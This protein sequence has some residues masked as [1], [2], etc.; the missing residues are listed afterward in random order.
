MSHRRRILVVQHRKGDEPVKL[1]V[2][3]NGDS[4]VDALAREIARRVGGE[5]K[6]HIGDGFELHPQ[7]GVDIILDSDVVIARSRQ[8]ESD[9]DLHA[10]MSK[11]QVLGSPTLIESR[12]KQQYHGRDGFQIRLVT[13][14][15][16]RK[17]AKEALKETSEPSNGVLAFDGEFVSGNTTISAL[18]QE[19]AEVFGWGFSKSFEESPC[20]HI[21]RTTCS[22]A[23]AHEVG[24]LGLSSIL[25][26]R[27]TIDG[28]RCNN[29]DCLFSHVPIPFDDKLAPHCSICDDAL[30][31]P[32]PT[33]L[34]I[35]ETFGMQPHDVV[36]CAIV[37]NAG[38]GHM[39][40]DHCL[41]E[42][43]DVSAVCP[44]GCPSSTVHREAVPFGQEVPS[45]TVIWDGDKIEHVPVPPEFTG[46]A[47]QMLYLNTEFVINLVGEYLRAKSVDLSELSLRIH[48]RDPQ[49][50]TVRFVWST[51]VSV[52]SEG[53]HS[54]EGYR[55]FPFSV[56]ESPSSSSISTI[57]NSRPYEIDFHTSSLPVVVCGCSTLKDVF[58]REENSSG[59][60][61]T[62]TLYVV[63]RS[64][65]E[66]VAPVSNIPVS[67]QS[68]FQSE[69]AWQPSIHQ[70]QRGMAALLSSLLVLSQ[71]VRKKGTESENKLL[72]VLY[73]FTRFPPAV[74]A[75]ELLL[76]NVVPQPQ[77][78]AA[79]SEALFH[80]LKDFTSTAASAFIENQSRRFETVRILLGHFL[81]VSDGVQSAAARPIEAVSLE[82]AL[83]SK[84]LVDPVML[85][86][87]GV[88]E[89]SSG[90]LYDIGGPLCR[91]INEV[92]EQ[93]IVDLVGDGV[94]LHQVL[95]QT[96]ECDVTEARLLCLHKI[97][98]IAR[99][100]DLGSAGRNFPDVIRQANETDLISRGPL[101]LKN[102]SIVPPQVVLDNEG[103]L[104]VFTGRGCGTA[105]DVNFYRPT[106]G[107]DT[108]VDVN[109]VEYALQK[110]IP[111]RKAEDTWVVDCYG[112]I[113]A[114]IRAPDEVRKIPL[115]V[116]HQH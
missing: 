80:S 94:Q 27:F 92:D 10:H 37:K 21:K 109:D 45:I 84:R 98:N 74:R 48:A 68:S 97:G 89:R 95:A 40:H 14:E 85:E 55:R 20:C 107:G 19:A 42:K 15:L 113:P 64:R 2:P 39:H 35:V 28:T 91:G 51:L 65:G 79:L 76:L 116:I 104:A 78:K 101:E 115:H 77:E 34:E 99:P 111:A 36:D 54:N 87:F 62:L 24:L 63:K 70:T 59:D 86:P 6:L 67:M 114:K 73:S 56:A 23:V 71:M 11:S 43:R 26:C 38:C 93:P 33:C 52:C 17:H 61:I 8:E 110:V 41:G 25:H 18:R 60:N 5:V 90:K 72:A 13:A 57:E 100:I 96:R 44:S 47:G 82:C 112:G 22:C 31:F 29:D 53:I 50:E 4:T 16:A 83:S 69:A 9:G 1:V 108:E 46:I 30:A 102:T 106:G 7:D 49:T 66:A 58:L 105:R 32:C 75:L 88:V 103:F 12:S 81:S 3:I